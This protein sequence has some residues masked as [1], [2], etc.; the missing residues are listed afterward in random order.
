[1]R[2]MR[3]RAP[4]PHRY[5]WPAQAPGRSASQAPASMS[6][7]NPTVGFVSL[8]CPKASVYIPIFNIVS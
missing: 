3:F 8:G 6:Q 7:L 1:M 5:N 4:P 2:G